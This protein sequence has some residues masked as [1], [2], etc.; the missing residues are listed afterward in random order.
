CA[1]D[2][3]WREFDAIYLFNPFQ[4]HVGDEEGVIDRTI[5]IGPRHHFNAVLQTRTKLMHAPLGTRVVT[6]YGFGG[7][8]PLAYRRR[9]REACGSD[10]LELWIKEHPSRPAGN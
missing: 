9:A 2:I 4:E 10:W 8:L 3:D 6:Y 7:N 5:S 1:F